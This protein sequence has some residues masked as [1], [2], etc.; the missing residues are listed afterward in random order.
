MSL[1]NE[2]IQTYQQGPNLKSLQTLTSMTSAEQIDMT[3]G[4]VATSLRNEYTGY[5]FT[6]RNAITAILEAAFIILAV[7]GSIDDYSEWNDEVQ[8]IVV[9][10]IVFILGYLLA[11]I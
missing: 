9:G 6:V 11:I 4:G 2:S 7:F 1:I 5:Y 10:A 8:Y 3:I